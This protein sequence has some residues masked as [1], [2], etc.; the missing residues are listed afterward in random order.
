MAKPE[1][2]NINR[3]T[4]VSLLEHCGIVRW[5]QP[6]DGLTVTLPERKVSKFTTGLRITGTNLTNVPFEHPRTAAGR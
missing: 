2:T 6:P 5:R 1:G 3:I 4:N